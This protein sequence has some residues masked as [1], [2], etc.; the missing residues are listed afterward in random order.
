MARFDLGNAA[1]FAQL[2]M[3]QAG[4]A[5]L[6]LGGRAQEWDIQ[7]AAYGHENLILFHVFKSNSEYDG[8][9][10]SVSD[11][12]GKRKVYYEFPYQDGQSS[13]DMGRRGSS[14]EFNVVIFGPKYKRGLQQLIKEL[15]DPR[16][17]VLV[18]P[19]FGRVNVVADDWKITHQ[20]SERQAAT[21]QIRFV[22]HS[23]DFGL[24]FSVKDVKSLIA[25]ALKFFKKID[26]VLVFINANTILLQTVKNVLATGMEGY[27]SLYSE[28]LAKLNKTFNSSGSDDFPSL[29]PT[30]EGGSSSTF[31]VAQ[32]PSDPFNAVP[33]DDIEDSDFAALASQQATDQVITLRNSLNEQIAA[34]EDSLEGEGSLEFADQI[35][36]LKASGIAIQAILE[37]GLKSSSAKVVNYTAPRTMSVRELAFENGLHPDRAIEIELLNPQ[38]LSLNQIA[39][40]TIVKVPTA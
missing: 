36:D 39:A 16:P 17:G 20:H 12:Y 1:D 21:L 14:F 8:A 27:K 15:N 24:D 2:T 11:A 28:T 25:E 32:S 7:E 5:L 31:P 30:N 4:S 18:H 38:L 9:V 22:E 10:P 29:L 40:G 6:A 23:F 37:T 13:D 19:V 26:D 33:V 35:R 3:A 34:L